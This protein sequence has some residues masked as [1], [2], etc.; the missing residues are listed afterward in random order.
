MLSAPVSTKTYLRTIKNSRDIFVA[1]EIW[2]FNICGD[3]LRK[4]FSVPSTFKFYLHHIPHID[5]SGASF[6]CRSGIFSDIFRLFFEKI[7]VVK[8]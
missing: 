4:R 2:V 6:C 8:V 5:I 7:A 3:K 1:A